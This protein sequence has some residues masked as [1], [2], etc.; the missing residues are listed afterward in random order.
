M[1]HMPLIVRLLLCFAALLWSLAGFGQSTPAGG[2]VTVT[3]AAASATRIETEVVVM[4]DSSAAPDVIKRKPGKFFL[5]LKSKTGSALPSVVFDSPNFAPSQLS[6]FT[7][8]FNAALF[9]RLHHGA[10]LLD[11]PPGELDLKSQ[12]TGKVLL[13]ITIQ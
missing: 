1:N 6:A 13:K 7:Q 8:D 12:A 10:L 3:A 11:L 5:A 9:Q 4:T 2:P